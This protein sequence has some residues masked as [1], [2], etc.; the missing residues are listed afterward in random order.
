MK[1]YSI[2]NEEAARSGFT[3]KFVLDFADVAA[4]GANAAGAIALMPYTAGTLFRSAAFKLVTAFDGGATSTMVLDVGHNGAT[5]DDPDSLI[6]NVVVHLDGTEVNYQ[7]GNGAVFATLRTGYAAEDAGNIEA[8]FT[9]TG[10]NLNLITSGE[11]HIY[12]GV[13]DLTKI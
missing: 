11:I 1:T 4:L 2:S 10:G 7:D 8:T 5:T 9:A 12:L 3:H 13:T 6:D